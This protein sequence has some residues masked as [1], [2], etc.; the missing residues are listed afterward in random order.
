MR[1]LKNHELLKTTT[2]SRTYRMAQRAKVT[3]CPF[4]G[5]HSGCNWRPSQWDRSWKK[6][7]KTQYKN[8]LH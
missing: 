3:G 1:K 2:D 4:C 8:L 7:R 6:F 5:P